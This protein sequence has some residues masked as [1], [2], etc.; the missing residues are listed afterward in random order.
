MA[1]CVFPQCGVQ[2]IHKYSGIRLFKIPTRKCDFY[3][4]WRT[5]LINVISR[6]R[7]V[8]KTL[9]E[10]IMKGKVYVCERHFLPEDIERT[11]K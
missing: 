9:K 6:Y 11:G 2:R 3:T 1:N 7:L 4:E 10:R 8:G 5:N